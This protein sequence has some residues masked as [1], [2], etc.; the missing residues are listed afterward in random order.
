MID[1][2]S[3][4][5]AIPREL[6][7]KFNLKKFNV[8]FKDLGLDSLDHFTILMSIMDKYKIDIPEK[9]IKNLNSLNKI[10]LFITNNKKK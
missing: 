7:K 2:K 3:L 9:K 5:E 1:K 8:I 10:Y 4:F 6:K